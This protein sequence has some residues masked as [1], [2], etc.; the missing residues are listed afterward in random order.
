M[1]GPSRKN[2]QWSCCFIWLSP[3]SPSCICG[4]REGWK[5]FTPATQTWSSFRL[6]S[7]LHW[8]EW[9]IWSI[10]CF[11]ILNHIAFMEQ[12]SSIK[13]IKATSSSTVI[14]LL[15]NRSICF[16]CQRKQRY[17]TELLHGNFH[18]KIQTIGWMWI[19]TLPDLFLSPIEKEEKRDSCAISCILLRLYAKSFCPGM[20]WCS[21]IYCNI[22]HFMFYLFRQSSP[23]HYP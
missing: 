10:L 9:K 18:N 13:Q 7:F 14:Q 12:I 4:K 15:S 6:P 21:S 22:I 23:A 16:S 19:A 20:K 3:W 5:E 8:G 17:P 11:S 2:A 1:R